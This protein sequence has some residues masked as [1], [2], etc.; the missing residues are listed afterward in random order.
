[1]PVVTDVPTKEWEEFYKSRAEIPIF[2]SPS[3]YQV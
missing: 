2:Q 1:M 3:M